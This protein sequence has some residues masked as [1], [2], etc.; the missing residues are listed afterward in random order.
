MSFVW[1]R[2]LP[3]LAGLSGLLIGIGVGFLLARAT[4]S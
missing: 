1:R 2:S 3:S 4:R